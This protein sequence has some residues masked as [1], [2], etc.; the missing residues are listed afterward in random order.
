MAKKY[1][2]VH[3]VRMVLNALKGRDL[4]VAQIAQV[5][6]LHYE[7]VRRI[8]RD[9]DSE[10]VIVKNYHNAKHITHH[11]LDDHRK[12]TIP[13]NSLGNRSILDVWYASKGSPVGTIAYTFRE[14]LT[15][16]FIAAKKQANGHNIEADLRIARKEI[17]LRIK[18][19]DEEIQLLEYLKDDPLIWNTTAMETWPS[20]PDWTKYSEEIPNG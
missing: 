12:R 16:V 13:T 9:L 4:T 2:G 1:S 11:L 20:D 7:T 14:A 5:S 6:G 17:D 3:K 8:V 10:G 15:R 18:K 19:L